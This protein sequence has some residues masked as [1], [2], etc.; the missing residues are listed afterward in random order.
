M[1]KRNSHYGAL[2]F[3]DL[4]NFKS[5]NDAHGQNAG[6]MLLVE[7]ALELRT[8]CERQTL[9]PVWVEMSS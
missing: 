6:D 3:L 5:L 7:V 1:S 4:D 8:V 9:L 2:I